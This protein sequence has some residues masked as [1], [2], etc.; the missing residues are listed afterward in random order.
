MQK[1]AQ[2]SRAQPHP[3]KLGPLLRPANRRSSGVCRCCGSLACPLGRA[4]SQVHPQL[5]WQSHRKRRQRVASPRQ[6]RCSLPPFVLAGCHTLRSW[7]RWHVLL[8]LCS[9]G[10]THYTTHPQHALHSNVFHQLHAAV[11]HP[12][13]MLKVLAP[14]KATARC[15]DTPGESTKQTC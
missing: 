13:L 1:A 3:E 6:C 14:G 2:N 5:H 8:A 11:T 12:P 15:Q 4:W 9:G 10:C 7:C